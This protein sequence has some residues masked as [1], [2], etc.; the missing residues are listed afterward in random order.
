KKTSL[1]YKNKKKP[2]TKSKKDDNNSKEITIVPIGNN[3]K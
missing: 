3:D 2:P 1:S